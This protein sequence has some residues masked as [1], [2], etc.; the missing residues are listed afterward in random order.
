M[1]RDMA[2]CVLPTLW[3]TSLLFSV[4]DTQEQ[5]EK[6]NT[7]KPPQKKPQTTKSLRFVTSAQE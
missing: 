7:K 6:T 4:I 2:T 5:L 1:Y 3:K